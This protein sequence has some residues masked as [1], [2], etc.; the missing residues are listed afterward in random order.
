MISG[1]LVAVSFLTVIPVGPRTEIGPGRFAASMSYFPL[2]GLLIGL[3]LAL[4][5]FALRGLLPGMVLD[6][7]LVAA[8]ALFTG[9]LHLDGL[10]DT[11]DGLIGGRGDREKTLSVMKDSRIGAMGVV[12]LALLL[13]M[14]IAALGG[15]PAGLRPA[16]LMLAPAMARWSQV[17]VSFG[18]ATARGQEG[19]AG[20]FIER[21]RLRNYL[22]A[23]ATLFLMVILA[24]QPRG[25]YAFI[26]VALFAAAAK[27]FFGRRL[28]GVT[29]DTIGAVSEISE[30]LAL[31]VFSVQA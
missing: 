12:A 19:L 25:L 20:P 3:A 31:F 7:T 17:Q 30:T 18:S 1:F 15:M 24:R 9:G 11:V 22:V 21:L 27:V 2:V 26:A 13:A 14:K 5:D 6:V 29:G 23:L 10:A 28:G 8:L 16:A 4:M